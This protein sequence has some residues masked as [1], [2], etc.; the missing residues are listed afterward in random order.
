MIPIAEKIDLQGIP[1]TYPK[2]FVQKGEAFECAGRV[3]EHFFL[4]A[5]DS[6]KKPVKV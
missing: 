6:C 2:V 1:V 4:K 3:S 5:Y